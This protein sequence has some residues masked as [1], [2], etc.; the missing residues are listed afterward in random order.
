MKKNFLHAESRKRKRV[1]KKTLA[2]KSTTKTIHVTKGRRIENCRKRVNPDEVHEIRVRF[3]E[4]HFGKSVFYHQNGSKT[5]IAPITAKEKPVVNVK[6]IMQIIV[7]AEF[8]F[9][10]D[11]TRKK[12][13][14]K[15]DV[16]HKVISVETKTVNVVAHSEC[17]V[18]EMLIK[19]GINKDSIMT[20]KNVCYVT[21]HKQ[22]TEEK[23]KAIL[24]T[25]HTRVFKVMKNQ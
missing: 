7:P 19:A 8:F 20:S 12:N 5:W 17:A 24:P 9:V 21:L 16:H 3:N 18:K 22:V 11:K 14:Y 25:M 1:S 23:V 15:R 2:R 6:R 10:T 4:E 13:I